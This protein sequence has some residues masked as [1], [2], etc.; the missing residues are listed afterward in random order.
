MSD[1]NWATK[2]LAPAL[3]T[4]LAN[5]MWATPISIMRGA[6][7]DRELGNINP[8]PF[9]VVFASCIAYMFYSILKQDYFIF[10]SNIFGILIGVSCITTSLMLLSKETPSKFESSLRDLVEYLFIGTL[11]FWLIILLF[12]GLVLEGGGVSDSLVGTI[13]VIASILYYAAPL[14]TMARIVRKKDASSLYLPLVLVNLVNAVLWFIYGLAGIND[15]YVWLPNALGIVL[16]LTQI[17][18]VMWYGGIGCAPKKQDE[19]DVQHDPRAAGVTRFSSYWVKPKGVPLTRFQSFTRAV[20]SFFRPNAQHPPQ[21]T[22]SRED[23]EE[24][25]VKVQ[26][27]N[28]MQG[29]EKKLSHISH[30]NNSN[31][32]MK[33]DA[34][35]DE[36]HREVEFGI[37][38]T[39]SDPSSMVN[40][41]KV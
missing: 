37:V 32:E 40:N 13:A 24:D 18:L 23:E 16:A 29:Y 9:N 3:G 12:V 27:D 33:D 36:V 25:I 8:I 26:A 15:I 41:N 11:A 6:R 7:R 10:F 30:S 28:N 17:G 19:A 35:M 22:S 5:A 4:L 34:M 1:N 2:Y 20:S 14:S 31:L 39:V 21:E 38:N